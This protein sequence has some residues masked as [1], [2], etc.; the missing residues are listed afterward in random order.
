MSPI[1]VEILIILALI[2][3][4]GIFS[5]SEMAI[6]SARKARLQQLANQGSLNAQAAL[7]LAE[8][9]NHFLSIV[10][11]G[12][13]LINILNGVF[14]GAT[15]AQ[16]LEKYVELV[17]FLSDYSQTIAFGVVVLVI[18]YLSLIV[19]ELVPKRLA[20]NNPEKIAAFI[21]IPMRALASLASP[22]VY[23]LSI[24][25]E[26]VLQILGIRPSE[27]P[28]VTEEE[29]KILIEQGTE[30]G[31]FEAAEQDMVERVFRLGDRP[32]TFFMTPRPDIV[33]LDLDDSPEEN[34]Q[35]MS[36]SNYSRYPVC[37]EGLD[38]VLGVIPVTDLLSRSLRNEPFDLTIGLRQPV[39]VP[40]STRGLKVLELF[41]QTVTHIALVVD[42]YGVI[43]G[44]V[45]LNDIMSEIVGDVPAQPGQ[46]EP[47][48][49]QREDGSWL[50]DGM[51]PVEE[52]FELFDVE[53][54]EMEARGNYQ[55]LGGL[56]IT[57]LGR[58]PTAA[59]HFEWQG[60]RI[61]VM[62]MDGN[63]VDKVLV[64][65]HTN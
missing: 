1:T 52:F 35:K 58:I 36:A 49:V 28:Q 46:E 41:K 32:V 5:M 62:D 51:L 6:V 61:E 30:A 65:P 53:E 54:L 15:I 38:N 50:V 3:A 8:A 16:R 33:W 4:N 45:T 34:R 40:E 13:T 27:E 37:Q 56:V 48:A 21:A 2:L 63:R 47:Q 44:L 29:I 31:T 10:Q 24:S 55:T 9:P 18:T 19:G 11:V 26:T 25:T 14:G 57:N 7:E 17:P 60:M 64:V 59:E 12:I 22:I 20:L 42:E 23:M 43:Q 39:F